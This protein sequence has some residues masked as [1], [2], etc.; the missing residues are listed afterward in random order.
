MNQNRF[1]LAINSILIVISTSIIGT[2]LHE[3]A[4]FFT[5]KYFGIDA[6]LHHNYVMMSETQGTEIQKIW[7]AAM[8]P[9]FS[10]V[11]GII[12]LYISVKIIK[13]S[14]FKLFMI[15]LGM[16]GI[17][18]FLGYVLIAPVAKVGDT[19][20]VFHY[21][22]VPFIAAVIIAIL[23]FVYINYL[24]GKFAKH[25]IF[26]KNEAIFDQNESRKQLFAYPIYAS[27]VIMSLLSLPIVTWVSLLPTIFMP[28]TYF[29]TMGAYK[30]LPLENAE[31][32]INKISIPLV[33]LTVASIA[34]FRYL[35]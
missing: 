1:S 20:K 21:F 35:V 34:I 33:I 15:W 17:L 18:C 4:H 31:L 13:P 28:M 7:V 26:Y 10:L 6:Q 16:G 14:L 12:V 19:G 5:A 32:E 25:F 27:I 2:I 9:L 8:G 30:K 22:G 24:F 3:L 11:F 29:S 23:S